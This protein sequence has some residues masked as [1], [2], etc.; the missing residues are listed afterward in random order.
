MVCLPQAG[1]TADA[2][3]LY[4]A[5]GCWLPNSILVATR[6]RQNRGLQRSIL[7]NPCDPEFVISGLILPF[8]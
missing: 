3:R 6:G 2:E 5:S 1:L 8:P 4:H 7:K